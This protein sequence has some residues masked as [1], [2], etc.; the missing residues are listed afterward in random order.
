MSD[1]H[2]LGRPVN[3]DDLLAHPGIH[4]EAVTEALG[5]LQGQVLLFRN[6]AAHVVGQAAVGVG[7][8][9]ALFHHDDF[10]LLVEPAQPRRAGR[11]TGNAT[12]NDD[13]HEISALLYLWGNDE[14]I[15]VHGPD[16]HAE[17]PLQ[18]AGRRGLLRPCVHAQTSLLHQQHPMA[19]AQALANVVGH[20]HHRAALGRQIPAQ[21]PGFQLAPMSR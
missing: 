10:R 5:G 17:Y 19:I 11:A 15:L 8:I 16:A 1:G 4:P 18:F 6:S 3:G 13:L 9:A 12:H 2:G 7:N 20:R 21:L 14:I